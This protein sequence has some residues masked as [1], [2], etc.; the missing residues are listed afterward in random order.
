MR[1]GASETETPTC[2]ARQSQHAPQKDRTSSQGLGRRQYGKSDH[3]RRTSSRDHPRRQG[4]RSRRRRNDLGCGC[5][6]CRTNFQIP[7]KTLGKAEQGALA[8]ALLFLPT[9]HA[10]RN[11]E[12]S[13]FRVSRVVSMLDRSASRTQK[14]VAPSPG[15]RFIRRMIRVGTGASKLCAL[16][17]RAT[18]DFAPTARNHGYNLARKGFPFRCILPLVPP[19]AAA[20]TLRVSA[21]SA[22][23]P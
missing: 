2:I 23:R 3:R 17:T 1:G 16:T 13:R 9:A 19:I 12:R 15:L 18:P 6:T 5:T 10:V 14:I 11:S 21:P 7:R 4:R 22:V 20:E 8:G